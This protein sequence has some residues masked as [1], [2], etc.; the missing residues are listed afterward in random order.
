MCAYC[1]IHKN[2]FVPKKTS[3]K[4]SWYTNNYWFLH[5]HDRHSHQ[6]NAHLSLKTPV[7]NTNIIFFLLIE[8]KLPPGAAFKNSI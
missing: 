8:K 4:A 5:V 7:F 2:Y 1:G 3:M 6:T